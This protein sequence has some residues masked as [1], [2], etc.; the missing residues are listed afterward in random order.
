LVSKKT[1][2]INFNECCSSIGRGN[3]LIIN[4]LTNEL[5]TQAS[6]DGNSVLSIR[7]IYT[8]KNIEN[9]LRKFV[10]NFVQC[11]FCKSLDTV[12]RKEQ[13]TRINFLDCNACKS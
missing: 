1:G 12:N 11:S 9:V 2:W 6:I 13:S 4:Y 10:I 7:G 5:S 8:Q 3:S